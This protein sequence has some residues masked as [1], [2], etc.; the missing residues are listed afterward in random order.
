MGKLFKLAV[1]SIDRP[2]GDDPSAVIAGCVAAIAEAAERGADLVVLPEEPDIIAGGSH[3]QYPI[4]DHPVFRQFAEQAARSRVGVVST[5][6]V[7][8]RGGHANTGHPPALAY[9]NAAG[10]TSILTIYDRVNVRETD[11]L[12]LGRC[13]LHTEYPAPFFSVFDPY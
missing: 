6:S 11:L 7:A 10:Y 3:G 12:H 13:P 2:E 9:A 4:E 8:Y 5:L 1:A